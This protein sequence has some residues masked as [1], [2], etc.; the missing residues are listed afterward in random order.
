V[1]GLRFSFRDGAGSVDVT[2]AGLLGG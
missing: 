2:H 1:R